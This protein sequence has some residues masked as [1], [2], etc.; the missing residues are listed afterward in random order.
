MEHTILQRRHWQ[1]LGEPFEFMEPLQEATKLCEG[2]NATLDQVLMSMDF[3]RKHYEKYATQHASS[4]P[5]LATAIQT[6]RFALNKWQAINNYTPAYAAALL[7]HPSYR[8][9]YINQQWPPSWRAPAIT[10]IRALWN[11]KYKNKTKAVQAVS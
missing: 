8:E 4:N 9:V 1:F 11:D 6:S 7:L 5:V 2:D 3:L 10:A